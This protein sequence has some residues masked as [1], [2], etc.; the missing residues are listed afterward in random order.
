MYTFS[1]LVS[2]IN[3]KIKVNNHINMN[4]T[5]DFEDIDIKNVLVKH[6]YNDLFKTK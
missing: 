5:T 6:T 3:W 1:Y 2:V 4:K